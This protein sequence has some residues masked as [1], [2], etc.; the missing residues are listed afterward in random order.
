MAAVHKLLRKIAHRIERSMSHD[1]ETREILG[2]VVNLLNRELG[3]EPPVAP[4]NEYP[5]DG[6]VE[7]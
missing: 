3:P 2:E 6:T 7:L 5:Y 1:I 4:E